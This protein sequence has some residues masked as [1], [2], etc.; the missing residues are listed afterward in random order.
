MSWSNARRFVFQSEWRK[1]Y[2]INNRWEEPIQDWEQ[3]GAKATFVRIPGKEDLKAQYNEY[4]SDDRLEY[5]LN[6]FDEVVKEIDKRN[7][8]PEDKRMWMLHF[9]IMH[10]PYL[11]NTYLND[12]ELLRNTFTP[13]E[14]VLVNEYFEHPE[15]YQDKYSFFQILFGHEK[16]KKLFFNK[17]NQY[18]AYATDVNSVDKWRNS[19]NFDL[20][21]SILKKSYKLRL[22]DFDKLIGKFLDYYKKIE[23]NTVLVVGGDHGESILEHDYLTHGTIPYDEVIR[24][25]HSVHF[26]GQTKKVNLDRQ[27]SQ[28]SLGAMIEDIV[29]G[30]ATEKTFLTNQVSSV[31]DDLI[32]SFS[33]AGDIASIRDRGKWKFIYFI[34]D[35]KFKLFNIQKD[36]DELVDLSTQYEELVMYYKTLL[37]DHLSKRIVSPDACLR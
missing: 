14:L 24:F 16:F 22:K 5:P 25:F 23:P 17:D 33:C 19:K 36:P 15:K 34:N 32:Y 4:F 1:I 11:S 13:E 37:L 2:G 7:T 3:D 27:F 6:K 12:H 35:E 26:P 20:D 10:Y 8:N 29:V 21:Y 9:K 30:N 31:K 28:R 18:V